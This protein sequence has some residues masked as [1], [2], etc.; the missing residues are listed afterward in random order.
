MMCPSV[1]LSNYRLTCGRTDVVEEKVIHIYFFFCLNRPEL[2]MQIILPLYT[3]FRPPPPLHHHVNLF[4]FHPTRY[5]R[6]SKR[7]LLFGIWIFLEVCKSR[8]LAFFFRTTY[9]GDTFSTL[10]FVFHACKGVI[11]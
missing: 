1:R 7:W 4:T 8:L 9:V 3:T 10:L 5:D 2:L 6:R 11:V